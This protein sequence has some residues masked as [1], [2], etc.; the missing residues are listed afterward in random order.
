MT[1][2]QVIDRLKQVVLEDE[3]IENTLTAEDD[4]FWF[5]Q[6]RRS[7]IQYALVLLDELNK[8]CDGGER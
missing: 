2:D 4:Q 5:F 8:S 6:G 3:R 1:L 7:G